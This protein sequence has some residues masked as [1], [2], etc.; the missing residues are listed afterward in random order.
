MPEMTG[1]SLAERIHERYPELP[2]LLATG[3]SNSAKITIDLPR[4]EKPYSLADLDR[5]IRLLAT[6]A[7]GNQQQP[8]DGRFS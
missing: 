8:P 3:Y 1:L 4:L 7:G 6:R 5:Q 2:V